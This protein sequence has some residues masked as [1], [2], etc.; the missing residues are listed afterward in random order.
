MTTE[1]KGSDLPLEAKYEKKDIPQLYDYRKQVAERKKV[2]I[3]K[4][5]SIFLTRF[6]R[7]SK[8]MVL[9]DRQNFSMV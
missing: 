7:M 4:R 1:I 5:R 2:T 9:V 8:T 6:L 3:S